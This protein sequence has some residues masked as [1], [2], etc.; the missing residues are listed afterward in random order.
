MKER[1]VALAEK[2]GFETEDSEKSIYLLAKNTDGEKVPWMRYMPKEDMI[3]LFGNT[4]QLNLWFCETR[5]DLTADRLMEFVNDL[6]IAMGMEEWNRF[7]LKELI[8]PEDWQEIAGVH[9][10][11]RDLRYVS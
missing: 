1:L 3:G 4:D 8:D 11:Q 5:K 10:A 6:N 9:D 2:Y 7:T